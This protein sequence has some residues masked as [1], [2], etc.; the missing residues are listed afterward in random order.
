[1]LQQKEKNLQEVNTEEV[2]DNVLS[3]LKSSIEENNAE[4]THDKLP[5]V[6]ADKITINSI[7]PKLDWKCY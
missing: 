5:T 6:I 4:I 3:N 7:I 2:L 1:M